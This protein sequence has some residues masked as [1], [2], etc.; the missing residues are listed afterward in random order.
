MRIQMSGGTDGCT[1]SGLGTGREYPLIAHRFPVG[2]YTGPESDIWVDPATGWRHSTHTPYGGYGAV[3]EVFGTT[4][5][6][7]APCR[8]SDDG[9][10]APHRARL[11]V[12]G[13]LHI[14]RADLAL[15]RRAVIAADDVVRALCARH[16]DH[17]ATIAAAVDVARAVM[18]GRLGWVAARLVGLWRRAAAYDA[19]PKRLPQPALSYEG[20]PCTLPAYYE[21]MGRRQAAHAIEYAAFVASCEARDQAVAAFYVE[22]GY[23]RSTPASEDAH[24]TA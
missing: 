24:A 14:Q 7:A 15:V 3:M 20:A 22:W 11:N 16:N 13:A 12:E 8:Y 19:L 17:Q 4:A 18:A 5:L 21:E 1:P 6:R 2:P 9:A 10:S 23:D